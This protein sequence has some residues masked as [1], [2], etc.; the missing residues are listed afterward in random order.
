MLLDVQDAGC[1]QAKPFTIT[2]SVCFH[3]Q[4]V[5][6][7]SSE[8]CMLC[9]VQDADQQQLPSSCCCPYQPLPLPTCKSPQL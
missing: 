3:Y 6:V 8:Q 2:I 1:L 7:I 4:L 9:D 5:T